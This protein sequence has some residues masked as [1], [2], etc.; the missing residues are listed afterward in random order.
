MQSVVDM[1]S[2]V[3]KVNENSDGKAI[4]NLSCWFVVYLE[5]L[6]DSLTNCSRIPVTLVVCTVFGPVG[7]RRK[8]LHQSIY[9]TFLEFYSQPHC[10]NYTCMETLVNWH[11][12]L[13][14]KRS[15]KELLMRIAHTY[16]ENIVGK[17]IKALLLGCSSSLDWIWCLC[18]DRSQLLLI[19]HSMDCVVLVVAMSSIIVDALLDKA[20]SEAVF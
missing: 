16:F 12:S 17:G 10:T 20:V 13:M 6:Q 1:A 7:V 9:Y 15:E 5:Q 14:K 18:L 2:A 3:D 11:S 4:V 8:P 19:L